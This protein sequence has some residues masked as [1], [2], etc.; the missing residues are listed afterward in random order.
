VCVDLDGARVLSDVNVRFPRGRTTA[1]V[2]RS[3]AGKSVLMKAVAGLLPIA[4]GRVDVAGTLA[5][6]HQ[7]PAL[8]DDLDVLENVAFAC[9]RVATRDVSA[10][11]TGAIALLDLTEHARAQP[12]RLPLAVQKRVAL[13]RALALAPTVLVVDEPTTGLDPV[14]AA[15]VDASL[16]KVARESDTTLVVITHSPRTVHALAPAL[17]EVRDGTARALDDARGGPA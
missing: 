1:I 3:G 9:T 5:F 12:A 4:H 15:V 2:G 17:V 16:A 7:D 13:A 10:R 14:A 6:V 8:L 11:V